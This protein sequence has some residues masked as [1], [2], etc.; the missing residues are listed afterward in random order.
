MLKLLIPLI[1]SICFLIQKVDTSTLSDSSVLV[2]ADWRKGAKK[3]IEI[4]IMKEKMKKDTVIEKLSTISIIEVTIKD[5]TAQGYTIE[6]LTKKI[7]IND[8]L[9]STNPIMQHILKITEGIREEFETDEA[10]AFKELKNWEEI[11]SNLEKV[12]DT[13]FNVLNKVMDTNQINA[14]KNMIKQLYG[15]KEQ[16]EAA[17]IKEI[18]LYYAPFGVE[19]TLGEV[20]EF[21]A[22]L[23]NIFGGDPFPAK[24]K[25]ELKEINSANNTC[26]LQINQILERVKANEIVYSFLSKMAKETGQAMPDKSQ[27][28]KFDI[29]DEAIY[30]IDTK[31][32]WVK[33]VNSKRTIKT[34]D[35][36]RIDATEILMK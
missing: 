3:T 11:K 4:T 10:G 16:I 33:K 23:P 36:T 27:I 15:S 26:K 12:T 8:T 20:L 34:D 7:K 9:H 5:F 30:I 22:S 19:Y 6:W 13:L 25:I 17:A 24:Y 28:P 35:I 29:K 18:Q 1:L 31:E 32:G 14:I 21:D 2:K